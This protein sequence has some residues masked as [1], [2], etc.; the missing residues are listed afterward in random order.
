[1]GEL[2][3]PSALTTLNLLW[4]GEGEERLTSAPVL[5][6]FNLLNEETA[7]WTLS[8]IQMWLS[9]DSTEDNSPE[10]GEMN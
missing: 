5:C 3:L 2:P 8:L 1:M 7:S 6:L 9:K 4:K 10:G